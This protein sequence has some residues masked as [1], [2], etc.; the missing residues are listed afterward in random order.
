M[1]STARVASRRISSSNAKKSFATVVEAAGYKVSA[2]DNG[3]PTS[4][5]TIL[6]KAGPRYES[7]TGV[8]Q[9]LKNFAFKNT[10]QRSALGLVR[11]TELYGGVLSTSLTREHIAYTADFLR[12]DE[13]FFVDALAS[14]LTSTRFTRYELEESVIPAVASESTHAISDPANQALEIA[15]ALAFRSGLG[16]PLFIP[17]QKSDLT[18]EDVK[19]YAES[20]FAKDNVAILGTGIDQATLQKLV[21]KYLGSAPATTGNKIAAPTKTTYFGGESRVQHSEHS[22]GALQTLFIGYGLASAVTPEL[23]ILASHLST[24]PSVKWSKGVSPLAATLPEGASAS[25]VLLPY[26]DAALF[27]LL[28]QAPTAEKAKEAGKVAYQALKDAAAGNVKKEELAAA[29][30][31]A[32]FL[33]TAATESREGLVSAYGPQLISG[34]ASSLLSVAD[35]FSKVD[36]SSFTKATSTLLKS[37]PTFVAVGD[38]HHLPYPDEIGL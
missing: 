21:E 9:V 35:S 7:K 20:A 16:S 18:A 6:A 29:S 34:A 33:A 36:A 24:V 11:E 15:H 4:S 32:K 30:A 23:A 10:S 5:V 38:T 26:S 31:K 14:S 3:E 37:K 28:I 2:V 1:L 27:G 25:V 17:V 22:H 19:S 12:G 8:A 13:S